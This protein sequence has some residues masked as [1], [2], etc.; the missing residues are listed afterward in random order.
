MA[1]VVR[2]PVPCTC[3]IRPLPSS[4]HKRTPREAAAVGCFSQ[5]YNIKRTTLSRRSIVGS[6]ANAGKYHHPPGTFPH[7]PL[8]RSAS[9][10]RV[11][12]LTRH[13]GGQANTHEE[14][15][16]EHMMRSRVEDLFVCGCLEKPIQTHDAP[17][18]M[19]VEQPYGHAKRHADQPGPLLSEREP[20]T[21]GSTKHG[22]PKSFRLPFFANP[23]FTCRNKQPSKKLSEAV[24]LLLCSRRRGQQ[25]FVVS[26]P[27]RRITQ[28]YL[29]EVGAVFRCGCAKTTTAS[30]TAACFSC[31]PPCGTLHRIEVPKRAPFLPSDP[32]ENDSLS[33]RILFDLLFFNAT[34][35]ALARRTTECGDTRRRRERNDR[36]KK[37][38]NGHAS[39]KAEFGVRTHA[40][41]ESPLDRFYLPVG[42]IPQM[43]LTFGCWCT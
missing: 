11:R 7:S 5:E 10:W 26:S 39:F 32:E 9:S 6:Q 21:S 14:A 1:D 12:S 35:A 41:S 20:Q 3:K 8:R 4:G 37:C 25:C 38:W 15:W 40:V 17:A 23:T 18:V 16:S 30:A 42:I 24:Q 2:S 19:P 43:L 31:V 36:Y 27:S 22:S 13:G 33:I 28:G 29:V 34:Y